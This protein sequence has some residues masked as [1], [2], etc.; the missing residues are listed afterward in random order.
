MST[1]TTAINNNEYQVCNRVITTG[2]A[3]Y[4][5]CTDIK[6]P[7]GTIGTVT[8]IRQR[9]VNTP[10]EYKQYKVSFEGYP[11]GDDVTNLY[12]LHNLDPCLSS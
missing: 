7:I 9:Y 6:V 11:E 5:I 3:Q 8:R 1:V 12:L 4:E 10:N 2:N